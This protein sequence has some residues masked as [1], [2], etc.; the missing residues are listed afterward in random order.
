MARL[1]SNIDTAVNALHQGELVAFPTETVYGLG[2]NARQPEAVAKIYQAKGRPPKHPLIVHLASVE[3][4]F[5]WAREV[6]DA[7]H[8]LARA[9]WPGPLTLILPKQA[10][11]PDAV[12]G[13]RPTVG[14]RIP[15]HP[16]AQALLKQFGDGVAAP[17][18]N[19]FGRISPTRATH[20]QAE[21]PEADF[22]ILDGGPAAVGLESTIIDLCGPVP[23]LLRPGHI[24]QAQI[25]TVLG[26]S[27]NTIQ[28][29]SI[30]NSLHKTEETAGS[31]LGAEAPGMLTHHYAPQTPCQLFHAEQ[32]PFNPHHGYLLYEDQLAQELLKGGIPSSQ[33]CVLSPQCY[34]A[35]LYHALREL[36]SLGLESLNIQQPPN[37]VE[38][39]AVLDRLKRATA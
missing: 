23:R 24:T 16:M 13:E 28:T 2:A 38:W 5:D 39:T 36:D 21:F 30:P 31:S 35:E 22:P 34:A 11:V 7:A 33:Y 6:P 10:S 14:L 27:I 37:S 3:Q 15:S 20:V 18:A 1:S 29:A 26:Q 17:S 12:T 19:R 4:L 9:F 8:E 32:L 25:E